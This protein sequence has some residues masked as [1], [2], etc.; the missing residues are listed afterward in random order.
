M[1]K[2]ENF[3][4]FSQKEGEEKNLS[5]YDKMERDRITRE[6]FVYKEGV[7]DG[8][9]KGRQEGMEGII[10]KFLDA[11]EEIERVSKI[12]G[13]TKE[14]I[15]KFHEK[16]KQQILYK[17]FKNQNIDITKEVENYWDVSQEEDEGEHLYVFERKKKNRDNREKLIRKEGFEEGFIKGLHTERK[18]ITLNMVKNGVDT[19]VILDVTKFTKD[20]LERLKKLEHLKKY[21]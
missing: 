8:F 1:A 3:W 2:A 13:F 7:E 17:N 9:E 6:E 5:V 18:N 12:T 15:H 10:L 19:Q 21:L 16:T 4:D 14:K 20:E 11:G